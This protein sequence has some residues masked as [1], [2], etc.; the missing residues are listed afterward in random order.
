[1]HGG[2]VCCSGVYVG[3]CMLRQCMLPRCVCVGAVYVAQVFVGPCMFYR[4]FTC[5]N[6]CRQEEFEYA[7][8]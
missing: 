7:P 4:L 1:M 3:Q 5:E 8:L 2:S 6:I